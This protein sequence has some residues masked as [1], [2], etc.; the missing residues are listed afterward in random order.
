[1]KRNTIFR[2]IV[3]LILVFTMLAVSGCSSCNDNTEPALEETSGNISIIKPTDYDLVKNGITNYTIVYPEETAMSSYTAKAVS[4]LQTLFYDATGVRL[5]SVVDVGISYDDN[6]QYISVGTTKLQE[7]AG[8]TVDK[9]LLKNS[10]YV[11]NSKGRSVFIDGGVRGVVYGV[12]RFL[13]E[14]FGFEPYASDLYYIDKNQTDEKLFEYQV[15]C[16]PDIDIVV[17]LTQ[18][19]EN[20][21]LAGMR[22]GITSQYEAMSAAKSPAGIWHNFT[23][24]V[25]KSKYESEHPEWFNNSQL[26]LTKK[27][28]ETGEIEPDREMAEVVADY[29]KDKIATEPDGIAASFTQMDT[30]TWS[31]SAA[32]NEL[33]QKYKTN[34]A[35]YII[36]VNYVMDEFVNPWKEENYPDK[37]FKL[38]IFAYQATTQPP[39]KF[40]EN[41]NFVT[42]ENGNYLP[43]DD[44]VKLTKNVELMYAPIQAS[45]YY[46]F[47][48]VENEYYYDLWRQWD[49]LSYEGTHSAWL[50][51][52]NYE[53]FLVPLD[54]TDAIP[55]NLK[56]CK[57]FGVDFLLYDM[58]SLD[59]SVKDTTD[60]PDWINLK[61]YLISR[62]RW[63]VNQ[64]VEELTDKFFDN[65]F[66]NAS[67]TMR[68]FHREE[69]LWY[70]KIA[71]ENPE[72][73]IKYLSEG[74]MSKAKYW[75]E[76]VLVRWLKY[77]DQAY[78]DIEYL[79]TEDIA[80][81]NELHSRITIEFASIRYLQ[82]K[83]YSISFGNEAKSVA[84]KF[85]N[86]CL[87]AGLKY[88]NGV[89]K[90]SSFMKSYTD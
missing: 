78:S 68:K 50:Y 26:A 74:E 5:N 3:S 66:G 17:C 47:M 48:D 67:E 20:N 24:V 36:F 83:N 32:S 16:N 8:I 34:A 7:S 62:L 79:K 86:D 14:Q 76:E 55:N 37:Q 33:Y 71:Q 21:K 11:I 65:Y 53:N 31:T 30:G 38:F 88:A 58:G 89:A 2:S 23:G 75:P 27:N 41:G 40:D 6:K 57:D 80:L 42:D 12:Y 82:I 25:S 45:F 39:I 1:M 72:L 70:T 29:L 28:P 49:A 13:H 61:A 63:D 59:S 19:L 18:E 15:L 56:V 85:V 44:K 51:G 35:E 52:C 69:R 64:N 60:V 22:M 84:Q 10:G 4:E 46:D 81:Y 9:G 54:Q 73:K 87:N 77:M 43:A 90:I